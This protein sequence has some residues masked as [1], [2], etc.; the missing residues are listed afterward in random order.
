MSWA[1]AI[2]WLFNVSL[3]GY[4]M[5]PITFLTCISRA[6]TQFAI[7]ITFRRLL[8]AFT[9]QGAFGYYAAWCAVLW[10]AILL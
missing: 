7:S 2:C 9:P 1:T 10:V 5:A 6:T 8:V 4:T 3:K